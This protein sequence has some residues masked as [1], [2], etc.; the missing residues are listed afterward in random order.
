MA[1]T[2]SASKRADIDHHLERLTQQEIADEN[3]G[4]VAPDRARRALAAAQVA[5]IDHIIVQE[6]RR[7]HEFDR[8]CKA[9]MAIALIAEHA[10]GGQGHHRAQALAAG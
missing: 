7:V 1:S 6:G 8:G 4:L 3:T 5:F 9:H 10:G 2:S